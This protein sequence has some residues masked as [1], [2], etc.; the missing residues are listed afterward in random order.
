MPIGRGRASKKSLLDE[1]MDREFVARCIH[2]LWNVVYME[3]GKTKEFITY[4]QIEFAITALDTA[5]AS[6]MEAM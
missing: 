2:T 3:Q 5:N 1:A 6:N 4:H